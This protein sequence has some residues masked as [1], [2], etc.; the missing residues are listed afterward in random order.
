MDHNKGEK[1][2]KSRL[3]HEFTEYWINVTYM[4][5][6]FSAVIFYRRLVLAEHGI[7]LDDYFIGVIKALVIA[8]VVMIG[9]FM[10]ISRK[11]EHKP[12]FF[13]VIYKAILFTLWVMLFDVVEV[14]IRGFIHTTV[15]SEAFLELQGHV[16]K[17][18][19]GGA[20]LIFFIFIP[21]FAFKELVRVMGKEKVMHPF[22][23]RQV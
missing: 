23:Y 1:S 2:L 10:P 12:L 9:A 18:W 11:F 6:F 19:L 14:F 3:I 22:F 13:P 7:Y 4:A 15:F 8:K 5:V 16:T 21:F 17:V 20:M